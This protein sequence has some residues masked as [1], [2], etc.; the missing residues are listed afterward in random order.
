MNN[1]NS[2]KRFVDDPVSFTLGLCLALLAFIV[3][4]AVLVGCQ[5]PPAK[6]PLPAK[7]TPKVEPAKPVAL[8][9][10]VTDEP[11]LHLVEVAAKC[12]D[13]A[14]CDCTKDGCKCH[15]GDR[16]CVACKCGHTEPLKPSTPLAPNKRQSPWH[17][18]T[19]YVTPFYCSNCGN[20]SIYKAPLTCL[21]TEC[22]HCQQWTAV[23]TQFQSSVRN[24]ASGNSGGC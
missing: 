20:F 14:E 2:S 24:G 10:S 15:D 13:A 6:S 21:K 12:C 19:L 5:P 4:G 22:K 11:A 1:H 18:Q 9:D 8:N 17:G 16:C 3:L 7:Q 23:R